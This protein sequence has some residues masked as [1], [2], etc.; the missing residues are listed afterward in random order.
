MLIWLITVGEPLPKYS[1]K[2]RMWRTGLV[3][4]ELRR[5]GHEVVWW[6]SAFDHM[7]KQLF[8]GRGELGS[9]VDGLRL[10][11]L[12]G[13]PYSRNV[14]LRRLIN[15]LQLA[16]DFRRRALLQR[17]PDVIL[18]SFPTIELSFVATRFGAAN[19][20]PVILDVRDLWPDIF[21]EVAHPSMRALAKV[22]LSPYVLAARSAFAAADAVIGVSQ[23]YRNWGLSRARR[24]ATQSDR[25]F[26]LA[27]DGSLAANS[28]ESQLVTREKYGV[29]VA[30][31]ICVFVGSFGRTYDLV[32]LIETARA[33]EVDGDSRFFFLLCGAGERAEEWQ[34]LAGAS[35]LIRF[36]GWLDQ[37]EMQNLLRASDIGVA[38]YASGA[39]Q[40]IPNKI[41]E[42]LA[43][44][45]PILSSLEG[46][47]AELLSVANCGVQY[48]ANDPASFRNA[49]ESLGDADSRARLAKNG[50]AIFSENFEARNVYGRLSDLVEAVAD[51]FA[52]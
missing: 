9:D 1:G 14:S 20:I 51:D 41:I 38:A 17:R 40:G 43:A 37:R 52:D 28:L 7:R 35:S 12:R 13:I 46:E 21:V 45:L 6:T 27:Y 19:G 16:W 36:T 39:P 42:Y 2:A 33:L 15:H 25:V 47:S 29:P 34:E 4:E 50:R 24:S 30:A 32:P 22:V 26:P 18:C 31:V 48:E 3:A 44:G 5:R 8:T 10:E 23:G 49:L 11:F